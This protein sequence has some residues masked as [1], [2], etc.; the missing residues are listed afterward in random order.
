MLIYGLL[1]LVVLLLKLALVVELNTPIRL[2]RC[3]KAKIY[4]QPRACHK[5]KVLAEELQHK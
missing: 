5:I 1:V 3:V 2:I 4:P